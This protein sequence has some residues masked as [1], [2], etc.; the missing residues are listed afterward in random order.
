VLHVQEDERRR[1]SEIGARFPAHCTS[2]GRVLL[3]ALC[4]DELGDYLSKVPLEAHTRRTG[5]DPDELRQILV[6]LAKQGYALIEQELEDGLISIAMPIH[7]ATGGVVVA[8]NVSANAMR[9]RAH[10]E[11]DGAIV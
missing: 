3:A 9:V 1:V 6:K 4:P 11:F 10:R 7:D 8:I 2:M 5:T